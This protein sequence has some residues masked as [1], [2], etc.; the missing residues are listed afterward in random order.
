MA[1]ITAAQ[2]KA[3]RERTGLPMMDCKA[4]LTEANGDA[5]KAVDILRKRGADAADKKA[6]RE[7]GE[8]RI[9]CSIN[10]DKQAGAILEFRCETAPVANNPEFKTLADAF[11]KA[12]ANAP[13]ALTPDALMALPAPAEPSRT[14]RDLLNDLVNKI[15]ENMK[16]VRVDKLQ[17]RLASYVH[18]NGKIGVLLQVE[19]TAGDDELLADLCMHI[20]AM[21]PSAL[22]R[23]DVDAATVE[24]EKEIARTIAMQ[25]GKPESI[26]EKIVTGKVNRWY[27]EHVLLEQE[28]AN[29]DKFKG[30]ITKLL[31]KYGDV[32]IAAYRRFEVGG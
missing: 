19:G 26:V 28:F 3:L 8:G 29:A 1:E 31:A 2:V 32:K 10:R 21:K 18:F 12:A 23:N 14:C 5:D 7:T 27:S 20:T 24:K 22:S 17:G 15:R 4:A 9:A 30:T 6:G 13:G 11:A 25:S 16:V